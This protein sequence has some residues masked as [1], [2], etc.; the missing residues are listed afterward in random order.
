LGISILHI[1]YFCLPQSQ[2]TNRRQTGTVAKWL[3]H[4][5]IGVITPESEEEGEK[6]VLVHFRQIKQ[7]LRGFI[8]LEAG[9][10]VEYD[11]SPE[12]RPEEPGDPGGRTEEPGETDFSAFLAQTDWAFF[13][14]FTLNGP[15]RFR[16]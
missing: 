8:S 9:E 2:P 7:T 10:T 11:F 14:F 12:E 6:D 15:D 5:G 13:T 1:C 3:N 16:L 4:R